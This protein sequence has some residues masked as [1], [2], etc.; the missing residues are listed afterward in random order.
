MKSHMLLNITVK[1]MESCYARYYGYDVWTEK[2]KYVANET[3]PVRFKRL[4]E[5]V[6]GS[7]MNPRGPNK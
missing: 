7:F 2:V 3:L 1:V 4:A 6:Y 5:I